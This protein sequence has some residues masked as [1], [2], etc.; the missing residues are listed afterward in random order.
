MSVTVKSLKKENDSLK[1]QI[2]AL[3]GDFQNLEA[4]LRRHETTTD[5]GR[6]ILQAWMLRLKIIL[7]STA[8]HDDLNRFKE[9]AIEDLQL[10]KNRMNALAD[11]VENIATAIEQTQRYSYQYNVKITGIPEHNPHESAVETTTLCVRLFQNLGVEVTLQDID[12][13]HRVPVR[14]AT[15]ASKPIICKFVRRV[16]KEQ[17]M[18]VRKDVCK[19]SATDIGLQMDKS[20]EEARILDHLTPQVQKLLADAKKYQQQI[21]FRYCWVKNFIVFLRKTEDSRPI[22]I[23]TRSDLERLIENENSS[24]R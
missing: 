1:E 22:S 9:N 17:I 2:N 18:R 5:N 10:L 6:R 12:I 19:V 14:N 11:K 8:N 24:S 16:V 15:S 21:G 20:L 3:T 7:S 13:A 23:K 4:N